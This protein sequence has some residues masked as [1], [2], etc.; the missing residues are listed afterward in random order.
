MYSWA[1]I[2]IPAALRQVL[3]PDEVVQEVWLRAMEK[4]DTYCS[5]TT[6]FRPWVFRIAGY[7]F[8]E[9]LRK[10]ARRSVPT[11]RD[12]GRGLAVSQIPAEV[13]SVSRRAARSESIQSL[14]DEVGFLSDSDRRL[15][16]LRGL[17]ERSHKDV[18]EDLG[19]DPT[20]VMKRWQR[21]RESLAS[22][23]DVREI[24]AS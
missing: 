4:A 15:L 3:D 19:L 11:D 21:L 13:T 10:T 23:L 5:T 14:L 16:L 2:R 8:L 12:D 1:A 20:T 18:A 7:V 17:E 9:Q 6:P 24:L 22:R